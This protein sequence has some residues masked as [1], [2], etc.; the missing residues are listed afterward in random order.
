MLLP[1]M[2]MQSHSNRFGQ[3]KGDLTVPFL[4]PYMKEV[5]GYMRNGVFNE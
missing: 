4:P 1:P 2:D 5:A 3:G